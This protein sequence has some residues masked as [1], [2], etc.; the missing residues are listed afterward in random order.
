MLVKYYIKPDVTLED[1]AVVEYGSVEGVS[2]IL[3]DNPGL[4]WDVNLVPHTHIFIDTEYKS[5]AEMSTYLKLKN[6]EPASA[7]TDEIQDQ[8]GDYN[9]DYNTDFS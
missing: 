6:A 8:S 9:D 7:L 5:N 1:I 2:K 4:S 3:E